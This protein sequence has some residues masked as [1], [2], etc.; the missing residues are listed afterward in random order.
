MKCK[1]RNENECTHIYNIRKK[2]DKSQWLELTT[3]KKN[4]IVEDGSHSLINHRATKSECYR[5]PSLK[6]KVVEQTSL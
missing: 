2:H 1:G 5:M 4:N 6:G 3:L